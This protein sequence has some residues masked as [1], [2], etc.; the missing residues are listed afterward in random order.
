MTNRELLKS[1]SQQAPPLVVDVRNGW[2]YRKSH[3]KGALNLP[4]W[5]LPVWK[6]LVPSDRERALVVTCEHG[7]R[8]QL[9][10]GFL[11]RLGF[12]RIDLLKG[13]MRGWKLAGLP[14]EKE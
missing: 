6:M 2:E 14:L 9:A 1:L 8:A 10:A 11:K 4:L 3:I 12:R 7:P 13:H 5:K